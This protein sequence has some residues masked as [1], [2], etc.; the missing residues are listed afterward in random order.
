MGKYIIC[1]K[2]IELV[3][4]TPKQLYEGGTTYTIFKCPNCGYIKKLNIN[5]IHY[6]LDGKK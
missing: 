3:E 6:G 5:H 1:D 2:C 4:Y